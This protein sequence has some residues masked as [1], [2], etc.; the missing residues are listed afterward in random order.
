[1]KQLLL[2]LFCLS[3]G[4]A[5]AQQRQLDSLQGLLA[6]VKNDSVK[7]QLYQNMCELCKVED[8][9]KYANMALQFVADLEKKGTS[10]PK[11]KLIKSKAAFMNIL[12]VYYEEKNDFPKLLEI[13]QKMIPLYL[14]I[15]DTL[16]LESTYSDIIDLY[17]EQGK[18]NQ[19]FELAK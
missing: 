10:L 16:L 7:L 14:E 5:S 13:R 4:L 15:K 11:A 9:L 2:F 3:F 17:M 8:N 19:A 1:M 12:F 18:T 6:K